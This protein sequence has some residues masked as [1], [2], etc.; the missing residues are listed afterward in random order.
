MGKSLLESL[1]SKTSKKNPMKILDLIILTIYPNFIN[2]FDVLIS[3][4]KLSKS[5]LVVTN[6]RSQE[7][8]KSL[9]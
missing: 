5:A 6:Y 3:S 2:Q 4:V 7:L 9:V 8:V 1:S